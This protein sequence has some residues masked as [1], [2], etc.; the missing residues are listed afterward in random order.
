MKKNY[1]IVVVAHSVHGRI[2]RLHIPHYALHLVLCF[3]IFGAIVSIGFV[4]SYARM[5]WKVTEFNTLRSEKEALRQ[6]YE[7]LQRTVQERNVQLASLGDLASEVSIAFGIRRPFNEPA[8]PPGD[9]PESRYTSFVNQ[10]D[11]LQQVQLSPQGSNSL[12]YWL[13]NTTPSL[14]PVQGSLTSSFGKRMDPFAG[15]GAF[16]PGVDMHANFG[17]PVVA[18]ADGVVSDS[19]WAGLYGKRIIVNH[20]RNGLATH[21]AHLSSTFVRPGQVVRRGEVIGRVGQTGKATAPHLHYE[22]RYR[23][24]P[25]NP[26][27]YLKNTTPQQRTSALTQAD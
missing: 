25:V 1:L 23:N 27:R 10:Y 12:W 20:G 15:E 9:M 7:E 17:L 14:W 26:Y 21:Y 16:H 19:G 11:F 13:E 3:A 6:Q 22:V 8:T 5:L 18:A 24:T 4:S 2:R